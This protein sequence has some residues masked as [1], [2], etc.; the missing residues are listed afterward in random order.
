MPDPRIQFAES[1]DSI[2][3]SAIHG[4]AC[5]KTLATSVFIR[6]YVGGTYWNGGNYIGQFAANLATSS[7]VGQACGNLQG[8]NYGFSIPLAQNILS[9]FPGQPLFL[10]IISPTAI[11]SLEGMYKSGTIFVPG[12]PITPLPIAPPAQVATP[13]L[14]YSPNPPAPDYFEHF[15]S[16]QQLWTSA[17]KVDV[18][19][20]PTSLLSLSSFSDLSRMVIFLTKRNI[21]IALAHGPLIAPA[22]HSCG[23][24]ASH[25][26]EG[27]GGPLEATSAAVRL[28]GL[29]ASLAYVALDEPLYYGHCYSG[30]LACHFPIS[31]IVSQ[32]AQSVAIFKSYY[33]H[34]IIGD[35]EP[36]DSYA[37]QCNPH[38]WQSD[39]IN[40]VNSY[41]EVTGLPL[42]FFQDDPYWPTFF[43]YRPALLQVLANLQV[44][45][46]MIFTGDNAQGSDA[47]WMAAAQSNIRL[48]F[49]SHN[50]TVPTIAAVESWNEWPAYML[51]DSN[52]SRLSYLINFIWGFIR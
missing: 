15:T 44:P 2:T 13:A 5:A 10:Y 35:M 39:I 43:E 23:N 25:N 26:V 38:N 40:Y 46:G 45:Y 48:Y 41:K 9:A 49:L 14:W 24:N 30:Q 20:F 12:T 32:I 31:T 16:S 19:I 7:A 27:F 17:A 33:P 28:K 22:D 21:H 47:A 1:I 50:L 37:S 51:P 42:A 36:I 8:K 3:N 34:V 29:G 11:S 52:S 18:F 4:W 6:V